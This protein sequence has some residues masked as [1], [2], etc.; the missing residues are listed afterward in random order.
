MRLHSSEDRT[1]SLIIVC[2]CVCLH[3]HACFLEYLCRELSRRP[4][5][6]GRVSLLL[7]RVGGEALQVPLFLSPPLWVCRV[8]LWAR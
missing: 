4:V 5:N 6:T 7:L 2:V 1:K 3:A 8:P